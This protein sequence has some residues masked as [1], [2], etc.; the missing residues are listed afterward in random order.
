MGDYQVGIHKDQG[1]HSLY[2]KNNTFGYNPIIRAVFDNQSN[3]LYLFCEDYSSTYYY[4]K[5][6]IMKI[7]D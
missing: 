5:S 1:H 7:Y 4:H 2:S 6:R 3:R